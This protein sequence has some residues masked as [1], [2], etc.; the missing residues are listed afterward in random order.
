MALGAAKDVLKF[1]VAYAGGTFG[2]GIAETAAGYANAFLAKD[3]SSG[4]A[5]TWEMEAVGA[6]VELAGGL[7][8]INYVGDRMSGVNQLAFTIGVLQ[9]MKNT[10]AL[11]VRLEFALLSKV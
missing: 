2:G 1:G 7:L 4:S 11:G 6:V 10:Q 9:Q 8:L 5:G 3:Y